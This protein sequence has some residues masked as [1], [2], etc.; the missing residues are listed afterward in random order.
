MSLFYICFY[1]GASINSKVYSCF[2]LSL[3]LEVVGSRNGILWILIINLSEPSWLINKLWKPLRVL[4]CS[5]KL[6]KEKTFIGVNKIASTYHLLHCI[7]CSDIYW[8]KEKKRRPRQK[9]MQLR[10][11]FKLFNSKYFLYFPQMLLLTENV[12]F[13]LMNWLKF[14][15]F[16]FQRC[17][18]WWPLF[19]RVA[20]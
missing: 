9:R 16:I 3:E 19:R 4:R 5:R 10:I 12:S 11:S 7:I 14:T 15:H 20:Q 6:W 8:L 17:F 2:I 13:S 1:S 18:L